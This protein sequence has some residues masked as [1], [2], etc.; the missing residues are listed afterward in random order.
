LRSLRV[1]DAEL[2]ASFVLE[3]ELLCCTAP[4]SDDVRAA[5]AAAWRWFTLLTLLVF[6][7]APGLLVATD[8]LLTGCVAE[9]L[10][11]GA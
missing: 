7:P 6:T 9:L 5:G 3:P 8:D 1:R 4:V 11:T 2:R 10:T